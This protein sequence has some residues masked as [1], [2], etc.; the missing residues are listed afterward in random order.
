MRACVSLCVCLVK[1]NRCGLPLLTYPPPPDLVVSGQIATEQEKKEWVQ[2]VHRAICTA[3]G[4][5]LGEPP[6]LSY[7]HVCLFARDRFL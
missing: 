1:L 4:I 3:K 2:M 7:P 6:S 5:E